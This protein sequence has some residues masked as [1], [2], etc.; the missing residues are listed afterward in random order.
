MYYATVYQLDRFDL[1][2]FLPF[3]GGGGY[4]AAVRLRMGQFSGCSFPD[5]ICFSSMI[6]NQCISISISLLLFQ[7]MWEM[8]DNWPANAREG[9]LRCDYLIPALLSFIFQVSRC[10]PSN[11]AAAMDVFP[12]I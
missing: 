12:A 1:W 9:W 2:T 10:N 5:L 11:N 6:Y 7:P 4:A 8:C 3:F